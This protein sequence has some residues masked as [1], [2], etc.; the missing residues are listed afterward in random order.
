MKVEKRKIVTI[1]NS[2]GFTIPA[3]QRKELLREKLY[4]LDISEA[5]DQEW[6]QA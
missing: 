6:K 5:E 1:G 2:A 3:E 4:D